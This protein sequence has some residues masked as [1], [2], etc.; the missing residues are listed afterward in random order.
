M[1]E[2]ISVGVVK[3]MTAATV[4]ALP[5]R[6]CLYTVI[7]SGG[8][9]AV[10]LDGNTFQTITLDSNKNFVTAAPLIKVT[11]AGAD[12]VGKAY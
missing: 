10:S 9:I 1:T 2:L 5:G 6:L 7:T 4:Y 11:G 3:S 12:I 8:T